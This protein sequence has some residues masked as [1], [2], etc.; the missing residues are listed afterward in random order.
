MEIGDA[1]RTKRYGHTGEVIEVHDTCPESPSWR[2]AQVKAGNASH[3]Q[4]TNEKWIKISVR[5]G[6]VVLVPLADVESLG[7]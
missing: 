7:S 2:Q 4:F 1:V 6:G 5:S 3:A